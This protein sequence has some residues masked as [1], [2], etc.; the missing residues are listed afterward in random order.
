MPRVAKPDYA[1]PEVRAGW[2]SD[3]WT[4][5]CT[6]GCEHR[7]RATL[8]LAE[9]PRDG[10]NVLPGD[11]EPLLAAVGFSFCKEIMP[12][13]FDD[14]NSDAHIP[15]PIMSLAALHQLRGDIDELLMMAG[16]DGE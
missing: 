5:K 10:S 6:D 15:V 13:V 14:D 12:G 8:A 2:K 9:K 11:K 4:Y 7:L 1:D 3:G 16:Y